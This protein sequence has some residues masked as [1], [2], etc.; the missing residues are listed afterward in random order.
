MI[1]AAHDTKS[2]HRYGMCIDREVDFMLDLKKTFFFFIIG[3][4]NTIKFTDFTQKKRSPN[5]R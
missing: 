3:R 1:A 4:N 5:M 2:I